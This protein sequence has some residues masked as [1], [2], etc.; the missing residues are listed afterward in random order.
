[1]TSPAGRPAD[2]LVARLYHELRAVAHA[3]LR[4]ERTG[5]TLCTTAL[6]NEAYLRLAPQESL[7]GVD[8][9]RFLAA[10]SLT[11]RRLLVEHARRRNR[12]RRGGGAVPVPL[13]DVAALLSDEQAGELEAL[14]DALDRLAALS[15]RGSAVVQHR[16]FGGLTL[17]ET[18]TALG[19]S[20]KTV[21][22]DWTV[23]LAWLR[24][25]V[26]RDLEL[27]VQPD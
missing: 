6:V 20:T 24:K 15:P 10:A 14:D 21:Q 7:R 1:M 22:R 9:T 3:Q 23:A 16:F 19:V 5:H 2:D 18:A 12:L 17:E 26:A 25:E 8:R 11:M 4:G 27:F 13:D